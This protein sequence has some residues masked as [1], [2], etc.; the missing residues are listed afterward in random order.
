MRGVLPLLGQASEALSGNAEG[1]PP[2]SILDWRITCSRRAPLSTLYA[3]RFGPDNQ[4]NRFGSES[5]KSTV[6]I[7]FPFGD[8]VIIILGDAGVIIHQR[9]TG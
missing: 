8:K 5:N 6:A 9:E 4:L 2:R 1:M 3:Q 7:C